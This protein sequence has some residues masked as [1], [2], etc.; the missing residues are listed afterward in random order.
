MDGYPSPRGVAAL[1]PAQ[2]L[3]E[4]TNP[5]SACLGGH[6]HEILSSLLSSSNVPSPAIRPL[7]WFIVKVAEACPDCL[8]G[9]LR[10]YLCQVVVS[11]VGGLSK[12]VKQQHSQEGYTLKTGVV[13]KLVSDFDF[14]ITG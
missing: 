1:E 12:E 9:Q 11:R 4:G 3:P 8:N 10:D 6:L 2:A 7:L 5:F 14:W 13:L